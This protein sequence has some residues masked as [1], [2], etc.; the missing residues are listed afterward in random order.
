MKGENIMDYNDAHSS[1]KNNNSQVDDDLQKSMDDILDVSYIS[2][3]GEIAPYLDEQLHFGIKGKDLSD[4]PK[5]Y[6]ILYK[7]IS[8]QLPLTIVLEKRYVD[9]TY[10]DSYYM[11]YSS[12]YKRYSRFC[13]RMTLFKGSIEQSDNLELVSADKM[14]ASFMGSLVIRPLDEKRIGRSLLNPFYFIDDKENSYLKFCEYT[15][16]VNG[17]S[18]SVNAFPYSMQDGETTTC[19][20]ITILNL[21]D[22]FS[23]KY[24]NYRFVLPSDIAKIED[25]DGYERP[26]PS[27]GLR[28]SDISKVLSELGFSPRLFSTEMVQAP[29]QL[30]RIM[31]YYLESG[32]PVALGVKYRESRLHSIICVGHGRIDKHKRSKRVFVDEGHSVWVI[33]TADL[34]DDYVVMDDCEEP[35]K[36]VKWEESSDSF[37]TIS[38]RYRLGNAE[39]TTIVVPLYKRMFLEAEDAF[40]AC[41]DYL[42]KL[43]SS[44]EIPFKDGINQL[45]TKDNPIFVRFFMASSRHFKEKRLAS[46]KAAND[47]SLMYYTSVLFP[48]FVWVCE[49]YTENGY[50]TNPLKAKGEIVLDATASKLDKDKAI[51][52]RFDKYISIVSSEDYEEPEDVVSSY[53]FNH[54]YN[55]NCFDEKENSAILEHHRHVYELRHFDLIDSYDCNLRKPEKTD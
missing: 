35:Y 45:G 38:G 3:E 15:I 55:D 47:D 53:S 46:F 4:Q 22:Y 13:K 16:V 29:I 40:R 32:I 41:M 18:L 25:R 50:M 21:T 2:D 54:A 5:D 6:Q 10:R 17:C 7:L 52:V 30:K 44:L 49:I 14:K 43:E 33:D 48:K 34:C 8:R 24:Q 20:E 36:H 23:K 11:Y 37:E 51:I 19:A 31:H 26:L 1:E 39:L 28:Y 12:K 9:R 42:N 27:K